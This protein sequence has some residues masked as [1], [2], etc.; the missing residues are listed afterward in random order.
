MTGSLMFLIFETQSNIAFFTSVAYCFFKNPSYQYMEVV[1]TILK[2]LKGSK[3]Q[4]ITYKVEEK[5]KI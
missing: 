3:I 5:L 2:Y 1:K 4:G